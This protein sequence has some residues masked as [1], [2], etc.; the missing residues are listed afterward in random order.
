M[1]AL[2]VALAVARIIEPDLGPILSAVGGVFLIGFGIAAARSAARRPLT[3]REIE[4]MRVMLLGWL[5][6]FLPRPIIRGFVLIMGL[7]MIGFGIVLLVTGV[8]GEA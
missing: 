7:V 5:I 2:L 4:G 1:L 8:L 6:S 3:A